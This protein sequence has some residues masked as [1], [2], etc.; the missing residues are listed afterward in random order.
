LKVLVASVIIDHRKDDIRMVEGF[1]YAVIVGEAVLAMKTVIFA[2][3]PE[4]MI[5]L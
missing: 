1:I 5:F 3:T 2:F 4:G